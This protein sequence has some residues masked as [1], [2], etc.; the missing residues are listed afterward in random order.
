L[1]LNVTDER[2]PACNPLDVERVEIRAP[3]EAAPRDAVDEANRDALEAALGRIGAQVRGQCRR[4]VTRRNAL[5]TADGDCDDPVGAGN[6]ECA[7]RL[8]A[9]EPPRAAQNAC[10]DY[11]PIRVP[12]RNL[13]QGWFPGRKFVRVRALTSYRQG[14]WLI[15]DRDAVSF[16]CL[17]Q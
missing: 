6:G 5:C 2:F 7:G 4:P 16:T 10:T 9:F 8:M 12:L 14:R 3:K 11:V 15:G 17:P 1:C 13:A